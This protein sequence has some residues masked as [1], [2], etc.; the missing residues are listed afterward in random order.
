M[1]TQVK[2][3]AHAT[4]KRLYAKFL[5][6]SVKVYLNSGRSI[7]GKL[8]E[9]DQFTLCMK[10]KGYEHLVYKHHIEFVRPYIEEVDSKKKKT[11]EEK[12]K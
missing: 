11:E 2:K 9:Y 4:Q 3:E 5:N 10:V 6:Q 8:I 1:T 7:A 12:G